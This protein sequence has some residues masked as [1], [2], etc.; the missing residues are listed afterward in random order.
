[1]DDSKVI[2]CKCGAWR[3]ADNECEVC[4]K[5]SKEQAIRLRRKALLIAV[6][7]G[8]LHVVPAQAAIA[9]IHQQV[10]LLM[11]PQTF[12]KIKVL[13]QWNSTQEFKC[14]YQ[15]WDRESHWNPR[16]LNKSSG[17]FG[18]AQFLPAT[19]GNYK[20][21]YK[22]KAANVQIKAG[23]RYITK[24]YGSPCKAWKFW[25]RHNWY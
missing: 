19:W 10:H 9:P 23:L 2:Y 22:P 12:A 15:M 1:M 6:M 17:A 8:L 25:Q 4:K 14:L 5:V 13:D 21:P 16:A 24:R 20:L 3:W 18:I 11:L 7:V